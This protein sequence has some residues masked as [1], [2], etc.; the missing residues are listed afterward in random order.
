M[1]VQFEPLC[2]VLHTTSMLKKEEG[3]KQWLRKDG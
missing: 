1:K 3:G 2:R